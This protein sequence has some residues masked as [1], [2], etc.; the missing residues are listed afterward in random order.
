MRTTL[1]RLLAWGVVLS[2]L[3]PVAVS[4]VIGL[5]ALLSSLGDEAAATACGRLALGLG[6]AWFVA[7]AAT[8]TA[9]GILALDI[10]EAVEIRPGA[11]APGPASRAGPRDG[12][13]AAGE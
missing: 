3:L 2:L 12:D 4:V 8:A 7:L 10:A 11:G 1:R 5:A 9:G 6:V 13:P